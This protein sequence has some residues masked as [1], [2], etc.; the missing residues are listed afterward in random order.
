LVLAVW[1]EFSS[2]EESSRFDVPITAAAGAAR[3]V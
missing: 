3:L 1:L 2:A